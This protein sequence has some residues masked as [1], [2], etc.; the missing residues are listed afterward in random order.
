[1]SS[2]ARGTSVRRTVRSLG[3][4]VIRRL[5]L[6]PGGIPDGLGDDERLLGTTLEQ[7][8]VV[9]F[10]DTVDGLYQLRQWYAPLHALDERRGVLVVTSDSR[11]AR[12]V[13]AESGLDVVTVAHY[14][15]LDDLFGRG[16]VRL[17]LY[18]NH[19]PLNFSMLR[20]GS[21]AHVSLLHGDSDKVVSVSNQ[22]KAY[23]LSFVAG[24]AAIDR[25][26][27]YLHHFDAV[28]RCVPVGRPQLDEEPL[29]VGARPDAGARTAVLYAP[30][31]EGA[32]PSAA[33]GSVGVLGTA[34]VRAL[35]A[36]G[37]FRVL[38]RPHPLSGVRLPAYGEADAQ[39]R[40]LVAQAAEADPAAGHRVSTDE[41]LAAAF[42]AAD[43]LV[44][45]VS[46][47]AMD[48]LPTRRPLVVTDPRHAGV[49]TA[50]TRMLETVPRLSPD[51]VAGAADVL[52]A[53]VAD[54][55]GRAGREAMVEYYLGDTTPGAAT[56]RFLEACDETVV[57]QSEALGLP[58]PPARS[59]VTP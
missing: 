13:R 10:A 37:R 7:Q 9:F 22:A 48:W 55:P 8:V 28:A 43:L 24:Q 54:D 42:D 17:A 50:S 31:W 49:R 23:D 40:E 33:Y 11:T 46:A 19:N 2:K 39:I 16:D 14:A 15:T 59:R 56:D 3:G 26:G 25:L 27:T 6:L 29:V 4:K 36:D 34:L 32:Q 35:L 20:F 1:M 21:M 57:W 38:Y 44:S 45:D 18:V 51:D 52:H 47:V 12:A 41:S 5:G 58:V 30:T 53:E